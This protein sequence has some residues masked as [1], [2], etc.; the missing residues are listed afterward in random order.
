MSV[1]LFSNLFRSRN[2]FI[3]KFSSK[4]DFG[5]SLHAF[6]LFSDFPLDF[7]F[8]IA[9]IFQFPYKRTA[10]TREAD[11]KNRRLQLQKKLGINTFPEKNKK[12]KLLSK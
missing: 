12:S 2:P 10:Q 11:V 4:Q 5:P 7:S 3:H 6:A 1:R 8:Y 9:L